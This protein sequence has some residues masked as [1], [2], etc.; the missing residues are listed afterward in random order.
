MKTPYV[1]AIAFAL[2]IGIIIGFLMWGWWAR[3]IVL[4]EK[5]GYDIFR[6][7]I[8]LMLAMGGV[9]VGAAGYL[10]YVIVLG[11]TKEAAASAAEERMNNSSALMFAQIGYEYWYDYK[12][13]PTNNAN[14]LNQAVNLTEIA[15]SRYCPNLDEQRYERL[16]CSIKN[17]LAYYYAE[18]RS[19][20]DRAVSREFVDYIEKRI[21]K[22]PENKVEWTDTVTF[23][24]QRYP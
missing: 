14:D 20:S 11:K 8:T 9:V 23:V 21:S 17:N 6:D 3:P 12:I 24:R 2:G 10:V 4:P 7:L 5:Q 19:P 16:I 22:Y 18:R 1:V 15:Y 13:R